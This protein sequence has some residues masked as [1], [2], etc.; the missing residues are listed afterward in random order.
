MKIKKI[1]KSFIKLFLPDKLIVYNIFYKPSSENFSLLLKL[2]NFIAFIK[3][4]RIIYTRKNDYFSICKVQADVIDNISLR[5]SGEEYIYPYD[6]DLIRGFFCTSIVS[7]TPDYTRIL[8]K[9]LNDY[10]QEITSTNS[11]FAKGINLILDSLD[12]LAQHIADYILSY[13]SIHKDE[14]F[15]CLSR[16]FPFILYHKPE[17]FDEALQK[18]L[19]YNAVIWQNG[20][21]HNGLSRLDLILYPYYKHDLELGLLTKAKARQ[22]L[23]SFVRLLHRDIRNKCLG[24]LGDSGQVIILGGR[25]NSE[26]CVENELTHLFL[27]IFSEINLPDPKLILR[28]NKFT[29]SKIWNESVNCIMSGCGS[30]LIMNEDVILPMME[31]FGYKKEDC[32]N[33]G[34]SACWEPLILGKSFDQNNSVAS[35][36]LLEPLNNIILSGYSISSFVDFLEEY[37][38]KIT[39]F[40]QAKTQDIIT[41]KSPIL[42]IL[43][44]S[45]LKK[46]LDVSSGGAD[47]AYHGLETLALPNVVNSL[48]NIKKYVFED[49]ILSLED[50]RKAIEA[51]YI[52][53]ESI[54]ALFLANE[55]QFGLANET[56][57]SLTNDI[58][59]TISKAAECLT[60]NGNKVKIGLSSP[61]FVSQ[62]STFGASLDGRNS[63]EP[64]NVHISPISK[65]IDI[66]EI[67][68]FATLIKYPAN[69]LNGNVVDF[70]V[71]SIFAKN[72]D[73]LSIL[74]EKYIDKGIF[75][76]QLNMI[77]KRQLIEAKA[78]PEKYPNLIV[79]VWGFSAFFNDLPEEY[80]DNL[81]HR[82]EIY[83][84]A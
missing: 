33:L 29:S 17:S 53:F 51:N 9:S 63:G 64:F 62:A 69:C 32:F 10:R 56:V 67:L 12:S 54:K 42:T 45:C 25:T 13:Y 48:L 14:R 6:N 58:V 43:F 72:P 21:Y 5:F 40:I 49:K 37:K 84:S 55:M 16:M 27:E 78:H 80:K 52:G 83:E 19:F 77:S 1:I 35:I 8:D 24:I 38:R 66:S 4:K 60:L 34:T 36:V 31:N 57:L 7:I 68:D 46:G 47:Y 2:Y 70:F 79:R 11:D 50:C 74:L 22:K 75:E 65:K 28:A 71:P 59:S 73:K 20:S 3:H 44:D 61:Y 23:I 41:D 18:I 76:L 26:A 81:I 15:L 82:A 30:P 39:E